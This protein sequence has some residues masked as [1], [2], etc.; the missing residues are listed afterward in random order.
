M[1]WATLPN[2][3]ESQAPRISLA[4]LKMPQEALFAT[5]IEGVCPGCSRR[6]VVRPLNDRNRTYAESCGWCTLCLW[7]WS[8]TV[9]RGE[10]GTAWKRGEPLVTVYNAGALA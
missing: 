3:D 8:A 4:D 9:A 7:G 5:V 1:V 2:D 6:L 10:P